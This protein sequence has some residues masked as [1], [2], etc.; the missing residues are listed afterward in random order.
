MN[1]DNILTNILMLDGNE[2]TSI[3]SVTTAIN[4]SYLIVELAKIKYNIRYC[5]KV[6]CECHPESAIKQLLE[7]RVLY[8]FLQEEHL[9]EHIQALLVDYDPITIY[10]EDGYDVNK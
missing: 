9:L 8:E 5:G 6:G 1:I 2:S 4:F 10:F 3:R 7:D